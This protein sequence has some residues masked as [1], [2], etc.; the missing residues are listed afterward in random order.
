MKHK[1]WIR[2]I[3]IV[4]AGAVLVLTVLVGASIL[5]PRFTTGLLFGV[6]VG[7]VDL[8]LQSAFV[9]RETDAKTSAIK[10]AAA[11]FLASLDPAQKQAATYAFSDNVQRSNWS[12]FPEGMIPRGGLKLGKMSAEQ[13]ELLDALLAEILS[14]RGVRNV[15]YQLA[16]EDGLPG[17][18]FLR[19][20]SQHFYVAFLGEPSVSQPWMFQFGG[21]HLAFNVTIYGADLTFSPMLTGGQPLHVR[22]D[23]EEVFVTEE[24][25]AAAQALL[26]SLTVEQKAVAIL[27]DVAINALLGPGEYG[28]LVPC[29]GIRGADLTGVQKTLLIGLIDT[30]LGFI[31]D[32]DHAAAM[33]AVRAGID[34]TCF[35][36]WGPQEPLGFAYF[37]VTGPTLV[38]EYSP[39]YDVGATMADHAH[40]IYRNPRNDYGAAWIGR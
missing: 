4:L 10:E 24:E 20:G 22:Y 3:S 7:P 6:D 15:E 37:R 11:A 32:D 30:R 35:G 9:D 31:N 29:E 34:E 36:W 16:A 23:G 19:Y 27:G 26:G 13:R 12:N 39:Q 40:S 14:E 17:V 5:F 25:T 8:A 21:H 28:T 2:R 38:L 1:N 18:P 33:A